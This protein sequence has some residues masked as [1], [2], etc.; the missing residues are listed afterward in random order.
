[1]PDYSRPSLAEQRRRWA[2]TERAIPGAGPH[3]L[4]FGP[5]HSCAECADICPAGC[6]Y[7]LRAHT[8]GDP[9]PDEYGALRA[10]GLA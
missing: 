6:G 8:A 10:W 4:M 9:C 3:W 1:M 5:L 7:S 2:L